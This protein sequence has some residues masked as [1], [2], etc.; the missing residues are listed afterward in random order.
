MLQTISKFPA[1]KNKTNYSPDRTWFFLLSFTT[2]F[3]RERNTVGKGMTTPSAV[4][5][6]HKVLR[7]LFWMATFADDAIKIVALPLFRQ[8]IKRFGKAHQ[9]YIFIGKKPSA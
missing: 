1:K 9:N 6:F 5:I 4:A 3:E 8:M 7:S 2:A